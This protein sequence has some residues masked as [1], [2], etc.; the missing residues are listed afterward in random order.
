MRGWK[1]SVDWERCYDPS[2]ANATRLFLGMQ[3]CV[4]S[5]QSLYKET[6]LGCCTFH[7]VV[8]DHLKATTNTDSPRSE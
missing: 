5:S 2:V 8:I 6:M 1:T 3:Y 7:R 4:P